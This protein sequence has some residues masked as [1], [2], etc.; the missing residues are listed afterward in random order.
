LEIRINNKYNK[1]ALTATFNALLFFILDDNTTKNIIVNNPNKCLTTMLLR[2][3]YCN[4]HGKTSAKKLAETISM[5]IKIEN[6]SLLTKSSCNCIYIVYTKK[7]KLL[8]KLFKNN[9]W[10]YKVNKMGSL[11]CCLRPT[12][13]SQFAIKWPGGVAGVAL[14]PAGVVEPVANIN[15]WLQEAYPRGLWRDWMIY[16][17]QHDGRFGGGGGHC[18]GIVVWNNDTI[19]WLCHSVPK[20][21]ASFHPDEALPPLDASGL[22]YAQ[23]FQFITVSYNKKVLYN[24]HKQLYIV[25]AP[26]YL[27]SEA[28]AALMTQVAA[29]FPSPPLIETLRLSWHPRIY[30]VAKSPDCKIDLYSDWLVRRWRGTWYIQTWKRG[31]AMASNSKIVDVV[32]C[33][34]GGFGSQEYKTSQD[35]SKWG[36]SYPYYWVGD[37][38]R[39]VS[40]K[41]RGGG[42]FVIKN[43]KIARVLQSVVS[44]PRRRR[45][46]W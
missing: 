34:W 23:G 36:V 37:L 41:K 45:F 16:N 9:R 46:L 7:E 30:H 32:E 25:R 13:V 38:N 31:Q 14:S 27:A 19:M 42:G 10:N 3:E 21:P 18:K 4:R 35:H 29:D 22:I 39:M 26:I 11:L 8:E 43:R 40:Q 17:D 2:K 28:S 15:H 5:N 44:P 6:N 20:F 1:K 12:T 24:I 33:D